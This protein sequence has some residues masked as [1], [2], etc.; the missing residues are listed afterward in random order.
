MINEKDDPKDNLALWNAVCETDPAR[1]KWVKEKNQTAIDATYRIHR[2]TEQWGPMGGAWGTKILEHGFF[3]GPERVC[4]RPPSWDRYERKEAPDRVRYREAA[5]WVHLELW[6]PNPRGHEGRGVVTHFGS[7]KVVFEDK[8]GVQM[9][10]DGLKSAVTDAT[11]K[12]LSMLGF[13]ADVYLG[14]FEKPAYKAALQAKQEVLAGIEVIKRAVKLEEIITE[15]RVAKAKLEGAPGDQVEDLEAELTQAVV[16]RRRELFDRA[17]EMLAKAPAEQ[18][19]DLKESM[20]AEA[21]KLGR[22]EDLEKAAPMAPKEAGDAKATEPTEP[23]KGGRKKKSEV[24]PGGISKEQWAALSSKIQAAMMT[25]VVLDSKTGQEVKLSGWKLIQRYIPELP[26]DMGELT[27]EQLTEVH[28]LIDNYLEEKR[29]REQEAREPGH[30]N[31]GEP[32][33]PADL[34]T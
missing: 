30:E 8:R 17:L 5:F 25:Q 31:I 7:H 19:A 14:D 33:E 20:R 1:A 26:D 12:C 16:E 15:F 29:A 18:V 4:E 23:K 21:E 3:E 27:P 11:G 34:G 24:L 2:A 6:Y 28:H 13:N 32:V 10:P 9:E 22:L